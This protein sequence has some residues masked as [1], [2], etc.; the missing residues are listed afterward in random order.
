M[1]ISLEPSDE[2]EAL[3]FPQAPRVPMSA[4]AATLVARIRVSRLFMVINLSAEFLHGGSLP[5]PAG[6]GRCNGCVPFVRSPAVNGLVIAVAAANFAA[7]DLLTWRRAEGPP[8]NQGAIQLRLGCRYT[9]IFNVV[10]DAVRPPLAHFVVRKGDGSKSRPQGVCNDFE[11]VDPDNGNVLR[12]A[13]S[14]GSGRL[15]DAHGN[16]VTEAEQGRGR[17][18]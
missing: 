1:V 2:A 14:Q 18:G 7:G 6:R 9:G 3:P 15:V 8:L 13:Q 10:Q 17:S 4:A 12:N 11:I 5:G 16:P